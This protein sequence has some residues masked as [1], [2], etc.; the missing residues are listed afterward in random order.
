M[1]R[2]DPTPTP[3]VPTTPAKAVVG[4]LLALV[5]TLATALGDGGFQWHDLI[6]ALLGTLFTGGGV[7]ATTNR[8]KV[9]R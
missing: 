5:F 1:T 9:P 7:Y 8:P 4:A 3:P 2:P 6:P